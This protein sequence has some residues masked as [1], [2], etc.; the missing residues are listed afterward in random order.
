[1]QANRYSSIIKFSVSALT[2]VIFFI[3]IPFAAATEK[4]DRS[5]FEADDHNCRFWGVISSDAPTA[6]IQD[7]LVNLPNSIKNLGDSS[8]PDGW[9]VGYYPDGN[10]VPTVNRGSP[11][12]STDP[13]YDLAATEAANATPRIAVS[14]VRNTSSGTTP[15]SG[16]PHPFERVKDGRH[17]LMAQN[18]TIDKDIL[19][20]P[21]HPNDGLIRADYFAA[22]PPQYGGNQSEWIDTDLY[23]IFVMQT[24]EDFNFQVKP[25]LGYVIQRLREEIGPSTSPSTE[26]LNFFLTDGTTLWA[27]REGTSVHTLYY[28]YDTT[29]T[30]YSAVASQYPSASQG[31]WVEMANGELVTLEQSGAPVVENIENY[32]GGT[33]LVDNYFDESTDS[34]ALRT[35]GSGQDWFESRADDPGL[36]FLD[37]TLIGGN[38]S[39]KAGFTASSSANAYLSQEFG[40]PQSGTFSLQWDIYLDN[41][42]DNADLDRGGLMLIGDDDDGIS[43]PNSTSGDRFVFMAFYC[44]GGCETGT[45]DLIAREPGD[46]YATSTEWRTVA[47]G[48]NLD[49]WNTIQVDCDLGTDT[50]DVYVGGVL[51]DSGVQAYAPKTSVTYISFAQ[52]DD[53]S[54][55]F[56]VDNVYQATAGTY[57]T[58]TMS[59]DPPNAGTTTPVAGTHTYAEN[60]LVSISAYDNP[61]YAFDH[62]T[63]DVADPNSATTSVLMDENQNITAH[64]TSAPIR[65]LA[66]NY[67]DDSADSAAL[68]TNGSG[69]DWYESRG[70]DPS[71]LFL[72]ETNIGGNGS[73][74]AGF[75]ASTSGNVYLSQ[76]FGA[77][78]SDVFSVQWDIYIDEILDISGTNTDRTGWV[79]I[80][81]DT[82]ATRPGPNSDNSE[83]F[84]YLSFFQDGGG[85]TGTMDL[86][87]RDNNDAWDAFTTVASGLNLDQWYTIRIE[88]DLNTDTYDVFV[89][90][91]FQVTVAARNAKDTL[92]H[93]SFSQWN[94]G[95]GTFYVDNVQEAGEMQCFS[96]TGTYTFNTQSGVET[97]VTDLGPEL[98]CLYV[99]EVP[100]NH[101]SATG[102]EGDSGIMT[103][104]YWTIHG[105]QSDG[106]TPATGYTLNLTLPHSVTPDT[107]AYVCKHP[108]TQGGFGWDCDRT[109]S[110]ASTVW[111]TGITSLSDWAVGDDVGPTAISLKSLTA[112]SSFP[113][114]NSL[115]LIGLISLGLV[116][117]AS[118][119]LARYRKHHLQ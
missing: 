8:N 44:A 25:A 46:A 37:E 36:L 115:I 112:S 39:K 2:V 47:T 101:P 24:L 119:G 94:D 82:D 4:L 3:S 1:M 83:R 10:I 59:V 72:D 32:F 87:A 78:Q 49:Q 27:Y 21:A 55:A 35:N 20:D 16:D 98:G 62:W 75:T 84:V 17:W 109:G 23:Q 48:L 93:I 105:L 34:A 85:T 5:R 116:M 88:C 91:V 60:T 12:A 110:D 11:Q 118:I 89:D 107:N 45:A 40:S 102:S 26:Q 54:G 68:R 108:G 63:G 66:D 92:T 6:V 29:G 69:Q 117:V 74:K 13:N 53:G 95:A 18:G 71:L 96:T 14:H 77:P 51:V 104:R 50:Y 114:D 57:H 81:D 43:G 79:L 65:L 56:Y 73:K 52:W 30:P 106:S 22:N 70:D 9:S 64:Y 61:G 80:G 100:A 19:Y 67:F 76:E 99:D 58:L 42:A 103:G 41:I 90:D 38:G 31:S 86:V 33:L 7:H 15:S 111:L 113:A 97:E 28:L